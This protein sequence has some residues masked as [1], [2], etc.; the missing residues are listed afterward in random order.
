[1]LG[2][3][4]V[5]R[6][7]HGGFN[8]ARDVEKVVGNA[9]HA[10][11]DA[12]INFRCSRGVGRVLQLGPIRRCKTFVRRVLRTCGYGVLEALQGFAGGVGHGDVDVVFW[13]VTINGKFKVLSAR[14]VNND[15]L[16]LLECIEAVGGV[17]GG[18]EFDPKFIYSEGEGGR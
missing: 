17:G 6:N 11:D 3:D 1:M 7:N 10:H 12:F 8:G 5:E 4:F 13:V 18:K 16:I 14:W 15:G 2:A 9:L